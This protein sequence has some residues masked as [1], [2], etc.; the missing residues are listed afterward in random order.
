MSNPWYS[1]ISGI[2]IS[3]ARG[4]SSTIRSEFDAIATAFDAVYQQTFSSALPGINAGTKGM[5]PTNDGTSASWAALNKTP[6]TIVSITTQAAVAG[7][8]YLLTNVS[9]TTVTLPA[10]PS[11]NDKVVVKPANGLATNIINPNGATI[12]GVVGNMTIDNAAA[13]V[14]LQYLNGSWRLV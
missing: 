3:L 6:F 7:V 8:P 1:H 14:N 5:V 11:A 9:A 13:V 2:P 4:L 10:S 12:E